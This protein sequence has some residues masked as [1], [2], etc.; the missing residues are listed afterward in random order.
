MERED[1]RHHSELDD[2]QHELHDE[3]SEVERENHHGGYRR[4]IIN[5]GKFFALKVFLRVRYLFKRNTISYLEQ[6]LGR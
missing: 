5:R 1:Q 6:V 4:G 3:Q 2:E